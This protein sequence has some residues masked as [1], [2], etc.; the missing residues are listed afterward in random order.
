MSCL[1][2]V[3]TRQ[4]SLFVRDDVCGLPGVGGDLSLTCPPRTCPA[5]RLSRLTHPRL[6]HSSSSS[7]VVHSALSWLQL[8]C[9][10]PCVTRKSGWKCFQHACGRRLRATHLG[11]V[12]SGSR[13][14]KQNRIERTAAASAHVSSLSP[15]AS[16]QLASSSSATVYVGTLNSNHAVMGKLDVSLLRYLD[17]GQL[18]SLT[19]V[20]M[21]MKNHELVP[22]ALVAAIAHVR[23]GGVHRTLR[24]LDKQ[25]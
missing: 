2:P 23:S 1:V 14:G 12:Q 10:S 16:P 22:A 4:S 7:F 21:G 3:T 11:H 5:S 17:S 6:F 8:R 9:I 15:R 25:G 19:A 18:R 24:E 13:Q 20:E